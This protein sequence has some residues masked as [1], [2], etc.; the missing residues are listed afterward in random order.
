[1]ISNIGGI[2]GASFFIGII[3]LVFVP[4]M[5]SSGFEVVFLLFL[6]P[7]FLIPGWMAYTALSTMI[8]RTEIKVSGQRI[9]A[10]NHPLPGL[11]RRGV[12]V[13]KVRD[14]IVVQTQW[15]VKGRGYVYHL[16]ALTDDGKNVLLAKTVGSDE[17]FTFAA[18]SI[19]DHL[20]IRERARSP[21]AP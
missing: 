4:A 20:M 6:L 16:R 1:M 18:K 10:R 17:V 3:L 2:V 19:K 12:D 13:Q 14:I 15:R 5:L 21:N 7:F 8:N 11:F 9:T